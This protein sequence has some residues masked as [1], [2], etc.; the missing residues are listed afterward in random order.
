MSRD[1][2]L[3]LGRAAAERSMIDACTV[4][5]VTGETEG[6]GGVITPTYSTIYTG[7]CRVQVRAE[8]GTQREVGEA[9][10]IVTRHEIHMPIS[11]VGIR[12]GD[13]I[14]ITTSVHDPDLIGRTYAVRDVLTKSEATARRV[15]AVDVTS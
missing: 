5:R 6:A 4:R 13:V 7:A 15:T 1:S 2:V 14:T 12:E 8:A 11:A 3:A 9:S 10:L